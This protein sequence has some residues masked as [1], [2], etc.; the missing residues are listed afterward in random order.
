LKNYGFGVFIALATWNDQSDWFI[1]SWSK[2]RQQW[3]PI[4]GHAPCPLKEMSSCMRRPKGMKFDKTWRRLYIR[5]WSRG[6]KF[7]IERDL[8]HGDDFRRLDGRRVAMRVGFVFGKQ[9]STGTSE[10]IWLNLKPDSKW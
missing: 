6:V 1:H 7:T 10:I 2:K 9:E 4:S 3:R 5:E 8:D